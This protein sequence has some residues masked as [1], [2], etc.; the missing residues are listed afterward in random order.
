MSPEGANSCCVA[1]SGLFFF[2]SNPGLRPL[3]SFR[4]GLCCFAPSGLAKVVSHAHARVGIL[5]FQKLG[6]VRRVAGAPRTA[7]DIPQV[8][9]NFILL[10]VYSA[11]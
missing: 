2:D 3:R 7:H 1:P 8:L 11:H 10:Q 6:G 5:G 9:R 4:P